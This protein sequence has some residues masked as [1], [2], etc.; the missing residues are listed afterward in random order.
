MLAQRVA[1]VIFAAGLG[2][3]TVSTESGT[4]VQPVAATPNDYADGKSWLCRPGRQDACAVD[5]ATTIVAADGTLTREAWT[6]DPS[7]PIDC[8]YVYPTVSTD[9]TPNSDMNA[10]PAELND[11]VRA[12]RIDV[13]I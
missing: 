2:A 8:F 10:D 13:T 5:L 7:P 3:G 11:P 9:S 1:V 4:T 12:V 6:A